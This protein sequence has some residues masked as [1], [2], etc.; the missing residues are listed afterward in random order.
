MPQNNNNNN[1]KNSKKVRTAE[2][3]AKRRERRKR[4]SN[5]VSQG[6]AMSSGGRKYPLPK[7]ID[8]GFRRMAQLPK[9]HLKSL[10]KEGMSF[11]KCAFAPP[12]FAAND[13][14]G[15]PDDYRGPSLV[16]K[17]RFVGSLNNS[18]ANTD[19]YVL[20]A[21]IPGV[22]YF[23]FTIAAGS[24]PGSGTVFQ[25]VGYSDSGT[26]F[27]NANTSDNIVDKF[28][29][30]SNHIEIIPTVNQMS[31]TGNIQA[32]KLP[33][34]FQM[35][36]S[37]TATGAQDIMT[38][39]GLNGIQSTNSN[40]WTGPVNLG[41]YTAA[42]NTSCN[43]GFTPIAS[44]YPGAVVPLTIGSSDWGQLN[45]APTSFTGLDNNFDSVIIKI[46]GQGANVLNSFIVKT[47]ACVEYQVVTGSML[48]EY[49]TLSPHDT[50]ALELYR[51]IILQLPVGVSFEDNEGFWMR[52]L[53]IMKSLTS[54]GMSLPGPYGLMSG[55]ANAILGGIESLTV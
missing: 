18:V 15:V 46:T 2:Q 41:V 3:L 38:I 26:I 8:T 14:A 25:G 11:L 12:D 31:W 10:S 4:K 30:I 28:R 7:G 43:F 51:C 6:L 32:W 36:P 5:G 37:G 49:Q 9:Q 40:Q 13:V 24:I 22:A 53:K 50:L 45:C 39:S 23:T 1:N 27:G 20:L 55:G 52:V 47:W 16:K 29:F 19:T 34:Q 42:Y 33:I 35:R 21:P 54:A 48:Y 44:G 17:H